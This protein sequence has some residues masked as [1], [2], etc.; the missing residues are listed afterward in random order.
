MREH[1]CNW[2]LMVFHTYDL[3]QTI[4]PSFSHPLTRHS[5]GFVQGPFGT[6]IIILKRVYQQ[7]LGASAS[8]D[9]LRRRSKNAKTNPSSRRTRMLHPYKQTQK[10]RLS[11]SAHL[12]PLPTRSSR[13]TLKGRKMGGK[14]NACY[15][16]AQQPLCFSPQQQPQT[17]G[18]KHT[19]PEVGRWVVGVR[20][21][22]R[23]NESC[24]TYC[25]FVSS[26]HRYPIASLN[27][28]IMHTKRSPTQRAKRASHGEAGCGGDAASRCGD[29]EQGKWD[30]GGLD[31]GSGVRDLGNRHTQGDIHKTSS[32]DGKTSADNTHE[33]SSNKEMKWEIDKKIVACRASLSNFRDEGISIQHAPARES[34]NTRQINTKKYI[35]VGYIEER[36]Q[37]VKSKHR[38]MKAE[39]QASST[40]NHVPKLLLRGAYSHHHK[41]ERKLQ[42]QGSV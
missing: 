8:Q 27:C 4:A 2:L 16:S 9:Q 22:W 28:D 25:R 5:S 31:R 19:K 15:Q 11:T 37:N 26:T 3:G 10:C 35:L 38:H 20:E 29:D 1:F 13:K 30:V 24:P 42:A 18:A 17:T 34:N 12:A 36:N 6:T 21:A 32:F 39:K 33:I 7:V 41:G 40:R 14:Y 23:M